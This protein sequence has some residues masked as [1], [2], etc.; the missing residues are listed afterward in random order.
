MGKGT[1]VGNYVRKN[2]WG[3]AAG[4]P[5][6]VMGAVG[7]IS[8][9][10]RSLNSMTRQAGDWLGGAFKSPGEMPE[11]GPPPQPPSLTDEAIQRARMAEIARARSGGRRST[12]LT[13]PMGAP[14][15]P[16]TSRPTLLG[17]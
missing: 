4:D 16:P 5:F 10:G 8:V 12:F 6:G 14:G 2:P 17:G 3:F 1:K 11:P 13:G 7:S 15:A 9:N